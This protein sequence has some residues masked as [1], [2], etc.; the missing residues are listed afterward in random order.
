MSPAEQVKMDE[1]LDEHIEKGYLKPSKSPM[2]SPVFFIQKKDGGYC[3][4]CVIVYVGG[5]CIAPGPLTSLTT[6]EASS[7]GVVSSSTYLIPSM[8]WAVANHMSLLTTS[9]TSD[10]PDVEAIAPSLA[11][12]CW[13]ST[14]RWVCVGSIQSGTNSP[15]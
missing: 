3:T 1:F 4:H 11:S 5:T 14:C 6:V 2:A 15:W 9:I 8:L 12:G 7:E 10:F 13:Q